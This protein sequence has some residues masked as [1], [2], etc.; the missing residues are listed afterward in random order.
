MGD[1]SS[2]PLLVLGKAAIL[3]G[4]LAGSREQLVQFAYIP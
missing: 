1:A 3:R 4:I 2:L